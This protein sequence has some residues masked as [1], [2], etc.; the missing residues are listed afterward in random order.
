[1][2]KVWPPPETTQG[3]QVHGAYRGSPSPQR[4]KVVYDRMVRISNRISC[5][6]P[7]RHRELFFK[8]AKT[9]SDGALHHGAT[10]R[11]TRGFIRGWWARKD[12]NLGPTDYETVEVNYK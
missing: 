3:P 9:L 8:C 6:T 12:S 7:E 11:H 5:G 1:M 4:H 2:V 10:G